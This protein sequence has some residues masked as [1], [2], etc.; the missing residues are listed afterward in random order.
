MHVMHKPLGMGELEK[1]TQQN[2][3]SPQSIFIV[4]HSG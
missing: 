2:Q 1:E 3:N 4:L